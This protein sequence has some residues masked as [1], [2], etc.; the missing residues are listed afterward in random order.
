MLEIATVPERLARNRYAVDEES[1]NEVD[2][3]AVKVGRRRPAPGADMPRARLLQG[4]GRIP[5]L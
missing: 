1:H 2:K 5:V 3:A 4:G